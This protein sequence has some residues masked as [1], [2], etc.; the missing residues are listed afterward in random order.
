MDEKTFTAELKNGG[1]SAPT[2]GELTAGTFNDTHTHDFSAFV[3]IVEGEMTVYHGD[4]TSTCGPG[5]T[6]SL[7]AGTPH[8]EQVGPNG[9]KFLVGRR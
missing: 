8:S 4:Q 9:A 1:Y 6:F 7:E 3:L 2:S 5:E